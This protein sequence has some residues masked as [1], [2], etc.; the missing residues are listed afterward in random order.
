MNRIVL[1]FAA[2]GTIDG[3]NSADALIRDEAEGDDPEDDEEEDDEE[4]DDENEEDEGD[5]SAG[6]SE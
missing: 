6:Y 1:Q 3:P 4:E 2:F 5:D